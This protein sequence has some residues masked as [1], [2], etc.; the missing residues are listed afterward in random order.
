MK[1]KLNYDSIL[2]FS[3]SKAFDLKVSP[4]DTVVNGFELIVID[5]EKLNQSRSACE[6]GVLRYQDEI[7]TATAS[8]LYG[9]TKIVDQYSESYISFDV[10]NEHCYSFEFVTG[11]DFDKI[12]TKLKP[13]GLMFNKTSI[14]QTFYKIKTVANNT[15]TQ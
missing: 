13:I 7:W 9:F 6:G 12:N 10:P 1:S 14:D 8:R 4:N 3:I 11:N 15:Y 5:E 2:L